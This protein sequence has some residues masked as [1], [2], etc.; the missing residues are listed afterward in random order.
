MGQVQLRT[1]A[2]LLSPPPTPQLP[3]LLP[4][5]PPTTAHPPALA[6]DHPTAGQ[7]PSPS[8]AHF[9]AWEKSSRGPAPWSALLGPVHVVPCVRAPGTA[10]TPRGPPK[11][12]PFRQHAPLLRRQASPASGRC[13]RPPL[14][15]P[16]SGRPISTGCFLPGR[17]PLVAQR[18]RTSQPALRRLLVVGL[19]LCPRLDVL[20]GLRLLAW[21]SV[22]RAV[23]CPCDLCPAVDYLL[24]AVQPPYVAPSLAA[25]I[26]YSFDAVPFG[27]SPPV[28]IICSAATLPSSATAPTG[29][30][31]PA[32]MVAAPSVP[33]LS[34]AP[35]APDFSGH[36][37]ALAAGTPSFLAPPSSVEIVVHVLL[38]YG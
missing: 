27:P 33:V 9:P 34:T 29:V 14:P 1:R 28:S 5:R 4:R 32:P 24:V 13:S 15:E 20:P 2:S 26:S 21:T 16:S 8:E 37:F 12:C 36:A 23:A 10:R 35:A 7:P 30:L 25:P 19:H 18:C 3:P 22:S 38:H 31:G 11:A 17:R 6:A